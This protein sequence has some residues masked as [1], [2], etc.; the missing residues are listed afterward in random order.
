VSTQVEELSCQ[1]L[2]ELVT[3]YVEGALGPV[4][5]ASFEHHI[6]KCT[7]CHEYVQQMRRTIQLT[8][9][10]TPGDISSEAEAKLLAAFRDWKAG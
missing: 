5:R 1:E 7:G 3:D 9:R 8:G 6:G 2:V 4:E 10:L